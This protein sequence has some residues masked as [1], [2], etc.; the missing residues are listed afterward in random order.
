MGSTYTDL[1]TILNPG[2][3]DGQTGAQIRPTYLWGGQIRTNQDAL[4]NPPTCI[5]TS[6]AGTTVGPSSWTS[7][8]WPTESVDN[9]A[10]HSTATNTALVNIKK[11]GIYWLSCKGTWDSNAV[12]QRGIRFRKNGALL[13]KDSIEDCVGGTLSTRSI[14]GALVQLSTGEYVEAQVWQNSSTS[15]SRTVSVGPFQVV[16]ISGTTQ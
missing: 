5:V 6:A 7:V 16:Q 2:A 10:M 15:A 13:I 8:T 12:G 4:Y 3:I 14:I 11:E 9:F 1:A